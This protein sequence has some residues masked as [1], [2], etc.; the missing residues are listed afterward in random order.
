MNDNQEFYTFRGYSIQNQESRGLTP[1]MEDYLEMIY[2]L[3]EKKGYTR[4]NDLAS[5]LNVQPPSVTRMVRKLSEEA[6]LHYEKYGIIE[7]TS[8]GMKI[9]K[10]LLERHQVVEKFLA[11][12]GITKNLLQD[13]EK[14]EHALSKETLQC[15]FEFVEFAQQKPEWLQAF[16]DFQEKRKNIPK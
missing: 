10:Q 15:I 16:R 5:I 8:L 13:T 1:S 11:L 2:R 14:I 7:L 4:I 6:Y 3:A 12:L 9:G